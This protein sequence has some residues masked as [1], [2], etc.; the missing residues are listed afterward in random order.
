MFS[1]ETG[2]IPMGPD[3][4]VRSLNAIMFSI[5]FQTVTDTALSVSETW[6]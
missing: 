4:G 2:F 1:T 5:E 3:G 6:A